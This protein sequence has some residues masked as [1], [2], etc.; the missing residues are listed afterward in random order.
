MY[1]RCNKPADRKGSTT[2]CFRD[3]AA[4]TNQAPTN[5]WIPEESKPTHNKQVFSSREKQQ[6]AIYTGRS[7][8]GGKTASTLSSQIHDSICSSTAH[9]RCSNSERVATEAEDSFHLLHFPQLSMG[10][11]DLGLR[12]ETI[13]HRWRSP[14]PFDCDAEGCLVVLGVGEGSSR[15]HKQRGSVLSNLGNKQT[16]TWAKPKNV[17]QSSLHR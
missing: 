1:R 2:T 4:M 11:D 8:Q 16:A 17:H 7:P 3:A 12:V 6:R 15:E 10:E 5:C 9:E 13:Q 14:V